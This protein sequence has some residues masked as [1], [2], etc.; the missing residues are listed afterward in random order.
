MEYF[1]VPAVC[2]LQRQTT[3]CALILKIRICG[4]KLFKTPRATTKHPSY[5][6]LEMFVT[7]SCQRNKELIF[8]M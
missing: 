8:S 2:L 7:E 5:S 4:T 1:V 3:A 6:F